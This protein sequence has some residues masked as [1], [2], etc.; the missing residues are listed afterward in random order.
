M[1]EY[2]G[3]GVEPWESFKKEFNHDMEDMQISL[4]KLTIDNIR[5]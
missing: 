1:D 2:N 3:E 5:K 4:K